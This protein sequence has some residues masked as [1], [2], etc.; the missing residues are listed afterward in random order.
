MIIVL[1]GISGV[2]QQDWSKRHDLGRYLASSIKGEAT[3]DWDSESARNEFLKGIVE[4]AA[5]LLR[6]RSQIASSLAEDDPRCTHLAQAAEM[7]GVSRATLWR[8]S[9]CV[10]NF[11]IAFQVGPNAVGWDAAELADF[12]MSRRIV[13]PVLDEPAEKAL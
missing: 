3:L 7:L 6:L 13:R 11:P 1:A 8:W 2:G 9:K 4:D 5:R 10:P 12:L